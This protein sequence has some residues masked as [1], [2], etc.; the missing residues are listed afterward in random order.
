MN[1]LK[2]LAEEIQRRVVRFKNIE[3]KSSSAGVPL[4]LD[5]DVRS[6]KVK[7]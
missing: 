5:A 4:L 1:Y 7:K 6:G 3:G 2:V